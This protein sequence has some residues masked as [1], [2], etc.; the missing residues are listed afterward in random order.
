MILLNTSNEDKCLARYEF[1]LAIL[2]MRNRTTTA[3][4]RYKGIF[5]FYMY[6]I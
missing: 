6:F 2:Q 1:Y 3:L 5:Y 4:I